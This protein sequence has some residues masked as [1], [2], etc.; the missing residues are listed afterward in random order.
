MG[1]H[2]RLLSPRATPA[3]L[4]AS[5]DALTLPSAKD[6]LLERNSVTLTAKDQRRLNAYVAQA[7]Q[8]YMAIAGLEPVAKPLLG[9]YFALNLTKAFLTTVNPQSTEGKLFHGI[10]DATS[11]GLKYTFAQERLTTQQQGVVADLARNT[12]MGH[13]W[14]KG[15]KIQV[16]KLLPYLVEGV[17]LYADAT[18]QAPRLVPASSVRVL[19]DGSGPNRHAWLAVDVRRDALRE[20]GL[21]ATNLLKEARIFGSKYQLVHDPDDPDTVTYEGKS[22]PFGRTLSVLPQLQREYD[23]S[24]LLRNR[25]NSGRDYIVLTRR[26]ALMSSEAVALVTL[27]H[28]SNIARYRPQ[29]ID[30]LRGSKHSWLLSSWVDRACENFL[31]S[32]ASRMSA[33]EHVIA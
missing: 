6:R 22:L 4:W 11:P 20:R 3:D 15:S 18:K 24:L 30:A 13:W 29:H 19:S 10:S 21:T 27:L 25:A 5:I 12:G 26:P 1:A 9:Y 2:R 17:E 28:L 7:R 23:E 8:Y 31:L 32:L 14:P 33:E 16:A